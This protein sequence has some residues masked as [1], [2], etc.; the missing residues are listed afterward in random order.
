M[1]PLMSPVQE[2]N[3]S[4]R[5]RTNSGDTSTGLTPYL[6]SPPESRPARTNSGH[7][8]SGLIPQMIA[9][10]L[11]HPT[12]TRFRIDLTLRLGQPS[13][14]Y[15]AIVRVTTMASLN[16]KFQPTRASQ[17]P[18]ALAGGAEQGSA[19][20]HTQKKPPSLHHLSHHPRDSPQY[21]VSCHPERLQY[22]GLWR[23]ALNKVAPLQQR[24]GTFSRCWG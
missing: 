12:K 11:N 18:R 5:A 23:E 3:E 21:Q 24:I 20:N 17:I 14:W 15:Q 10:S 4:M 13:G 22:P 7:T 6:S 19:Q 2:H 9:D 16:T 1:A 8:R